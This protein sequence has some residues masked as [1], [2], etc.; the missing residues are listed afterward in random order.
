MAY[1]TVVASLLKVESQQ[2]PRRSLVQKC[3]QNVCHCIREGSLTAIQDV[4]ASIFPDSF[5]EEF[6]LSE[7]SQEEETFLA[8]C[9]E[10]LIFR[11]SAKDASLENMVILF[12]KYLSSLS[13]K[14]P[15]YLVR[16]PSFM[17]CSFYI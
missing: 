12:A 7:T 14:L 11:R 3:R 10:E 5:A 16:V 8:T 2:R 15:K 6:V 1:W 9:A 4:L 13:L 17:F